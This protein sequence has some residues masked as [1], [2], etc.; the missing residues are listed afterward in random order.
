VDV[1]ESYWIDGSCCFLSLFSCQGSIFEA[2][3]IL[4][5]LPQTVKPQA[6]HRLKYRCFSFNIGMSDCKTYLACVSDWRR[7]LS[8]Q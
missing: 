8:C 1:T 2:R 3:E 4:L 7:Y 5:A 6:V